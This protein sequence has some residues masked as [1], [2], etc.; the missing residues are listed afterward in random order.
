MQ[1]TDYKDSILRLEDQLHKAYAD[2]ENYKREILDL[3]EQCTNYQRNINTVNFTYLV[4][5]T[6]E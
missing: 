2:I 4:R 3:K 1:N 6:E 5:I